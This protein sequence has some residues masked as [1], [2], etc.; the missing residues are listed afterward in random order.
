MA[1]RQRLDATA[2]LGRLGPRGKLCVAAAGHQETQYYQPR[3]AL[4]GGICAQKDGFCRP[5]VVPVGSLT[6]TVGNECRRHRQKGS[7]EHGFR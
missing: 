3:H 4:L 5:I 2:V 7:Y 6:A 1:G